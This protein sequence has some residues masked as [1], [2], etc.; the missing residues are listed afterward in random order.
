M[1]DKYY[2]NWRA[3]QHLNHDGNLYPTHG[4][5]PVAQ[6]MD[7]LRGDT[8]KH[9]VSMSTKSRGMGL[10]AEEFGAKDFVGKNFKHGDMN[11]SL[12]KTA[13][14]KNI[15]VQHDVITPRPYSRKNV[16]SGT[17]AYHE[18]YPSRIS[19]KGRNSH[20]FLPEKRVSGVAVRV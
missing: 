13:D 17:K 20:E 9:I 4:L 12:V 3:V 6:Y 19:I 11:N 7:I 2:Q 14:E 10:L 5:G 16:L 15:L 1:Q 8:F 18:G